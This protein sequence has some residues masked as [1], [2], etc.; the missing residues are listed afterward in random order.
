MITAYTRLLKCGLGNWGRLWRPFS[1][2]PSSL[3][4]EIDK[5]IF[6]ELDK[7]EK[8]PVKRAPN[9]VH[10]KRLDQLTSRDIKLVKPTPTFSSNDQDRYRNINSLLPTSGIKSEKQ[11]LDLIANNSS[12]LDGKILVSLL[13]KVFQLYK[14]KRRLGSVQ[15]LDEYLASDDVRTIITF[16]FNRY[17]SLSLGSLPF[18]V[19]VLVSN[20]FTNEKFLR[21]VSL[22]AIQDKEADHNGNERYIFS[23]LADT[24]EAGLFPQIDP[25]RVEQLAS[26]LNDDTNRAP[27]SIG[28]AV[29]EYYRLIGSIAALVERDKRASLSRRGK[30]GQ[31]EGSEVRKSTGRSTL[32][33][34]KFGLDGSRPIPDAWEVQDFTKIVLK[35]AGRMSLSTLSSLL[36][37]IPERFKHLREILR[38][39]IEAKSKKELQIFDRRP[40]K[41]ETE[42]TASGK[43]LEVPQSLKIAPF[44][45]QQASPENITIELT[46]ISKILSSF[47]SSKKPDLALTEELLSRAV[48]IVAFFETAPINYKLPASELLQLYSSLVAVELIEIDLL[49]RIETLLVKKFINLTSEEIVGLVTCHARL[50]WKLQYILK[51]KASKKSHH[52]RNSVTKR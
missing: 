5:D 18:F 33:G 8:N 45:T 19:R 21:E 27:D 12:N 50:A 44:E 42:V 9:S 23:I 22:F 26:Q 10:S 28:N 1:K 41:Q 43:E 39:Q 31:G 15:M 37:N 2:T 34:I 14:N 3:L 17:K 52:I 40:T 46:K 16:I 49:F 47:T 24:A 48:Q 7:L 13:E 51:E 32:K 38:R 6:E 30:E 20:G 11:I 4:N 29:C 35:H 25:S 36:S